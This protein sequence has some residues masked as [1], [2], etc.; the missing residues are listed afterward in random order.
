[1]FRESFSRSKSAPTSSL[2]EWAHRQGRPGLSPAL[3]RIHIP[4]P[5]D[6]LGRLADDDGGGMIEEHALAEFG[7]RIDVHLEDDGG[8]ALQ[9]IGEIAPPA[10]QQ[11]M[12]Q[13]V[14]VCALSVSRNTL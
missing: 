8:P 9:I 6:G 3:P 12:R 11:R 1:M 4:R 10:L 7:G 14:R 2:R 13:P 5:L